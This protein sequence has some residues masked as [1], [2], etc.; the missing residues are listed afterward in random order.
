MKLLIVV[1]SFYDDRLPKKIKTGLAIF[2]G[3]LCSCFS[4]KS[5]V[6]VTGYPLRNMDLGYT[7]LISTR[8]SGLIRYIRLLDIIDMLKG[9]ITNGKQWGYRTVLR[10]ETKMLFYKALAR[11]FAYYLEQNPYDIVAFH[12]LT[13]GNLEV[14]KKCKENGIKCI[15]TLHLYVGNNSE[16]KEKLYCEQVE[17]ER[18]LFEETNFPVTV[19]SSGLKR[20]I[21]EDY[22]SVSSGRITVIPN[23]TR[24]SRIELE[25]VNSRGDEQKLF[26][27]IGTISDRKNQLQL[28]HALKYLSDDIRVQVKI[29]FIGVDQLNGRLQKDIVQGGYEDVAEYVGAVEHEKMALYFKRAF[30]IISTSLNEAFGLTFIEGFSNGVP[31]IFFDDLDAVDELYVPDAVELIRGKE[32]HDIAL[33][34]TAMVN[35][36]W[37]RDKIRKH[38]FRFDIRDVA[39]HYEEIYR[40]CIEKNEEN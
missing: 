8:G 10:E 23:G 13:P 12:D 14:L 32:C 34:I 33:A 39:A 31:A 3:E 28:L 2:V 24:L 16:L 15:V 29:L 7:N 9:F 6:F 11:K 17:R 40:R 26:L 38:A 18:Y 35:K 19:V 5:N 27:C 20:R 37:D 22:N 1:P 25:E 30:A 4:E 21:L 36:K